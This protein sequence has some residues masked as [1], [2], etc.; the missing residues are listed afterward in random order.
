MVE[1]LER[2]PAGP[3]AETFWSW[4]DYS[5]LVVDD[6]P[7][8]R[9]FLT[10]ALASRCSVEAADSVAAAAQLIAQ[11]PFDLIVLDIAMPGMTGV[12]W[13]HELRAQGY[14]MDVI[15][16]TAFADMETAIGA[17]R[18]G[19]A[20]F[21]LKPFRIDQIMS[22]IERC[23]DRTRLK[24]ENFLLRRE[25]AGHADIAQDNPFLV[26]ISPA[27][28]EIR[29]LVQRLAPLPSTVLIGGESGTGKEVVARALHQMSSRAARPFV[30]INCGAIAPQLIE[31]E[32]FGHLKGHFP[33]RPEPGKDCFFMRRAAP[34]FSMRSVNCR[35]PCKASCCAYWR[36]ARCVRWARS[37]KSRWMCG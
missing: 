9:N 25:M 20:D 5:V 26:G 29:A 28:Q 17:L 11:Y 3:D 1:S 37:G 18:G 36:I 27:I 32:L 31:S 24:R 21:I 6:E 12:A 10:R 14:Q 22:A 23:F 2:Q 13:L 8:M 30:A 19:A 4:P 34:C 7:G 16:I 15:L 33:V 35:W